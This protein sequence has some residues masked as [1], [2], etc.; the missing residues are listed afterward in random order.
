MSHQIDSSFQL[1]NQ[2]GYKSINIG[3]SKYLLIYTAKM[4]SQWRMAEL[5][6]VNVIIRGIAGIIRSLM[7]SAAIMFVLILPLVTGISKLIIMPINHMVNGFKR[8]KAGIFEGKQE[9]HFIKEFDE[10]FK[11]FSEMNSELKG[12]IN[13]LK[14]EQKNKRDAELKALQSQI[15]PHFLYNTLDMINWMATAKGYKDISILVVR[16]SRLF[17]ICLSNGNTFIKLSMEL[18]HSRLYSQIQQTRFKGRFEY[19]ENVDMEFLSCLIPKIII[20]PFVEN[21]IIHGF[22]GI[23]VDKPEIRISSKRIDLEKFMIIIEDNGIGL[24]DGV[25]NQ[26]KCL[27]KQNG[28]LLLSGYGIKNVNE[29]I[30]MYF[31]PS[32]GVNIRNN[33]TNGT[34]VEIILPIIYSPDKIEGMDGE[35]VR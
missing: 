6:H 10:L 29:R 18:E 35:M 20:Q 9:R 1:P 30:Q 25:L 24:N 23:S 3:N 14:V 13:R 34:R 2:E 19:I 16:L 4:Q 21:S 11:S 28:P 26:C 8:V 22:D 17:R 32:Y 12:L 27:S 33:D 31:G 5:I 7:L 15:N